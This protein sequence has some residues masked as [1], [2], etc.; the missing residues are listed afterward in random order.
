MAKPKES[1][2]TQFARKGGTARAAK[3]TPEE[4]T[5][6]ARK[7]VQERWRRWREKKEAGTEEKRGSREGNRG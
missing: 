4:R 2:A 7:A 1:Y 5:E 3:L 6:I